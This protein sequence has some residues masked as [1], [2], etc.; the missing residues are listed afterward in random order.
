MLLFYKWQINSV[1]NKKKL[2]FL[3]KLRVRHST[4]WDRCLIDKKKY[5][6]QVINI[7]NKKNSIIFNLISY[8]H[9]FG[10]I[11]SLKKM[12]K[13]ILFFIYAFLLFIFPRKYCNTFCRSGV[14]IQ[15]KSQT[16]FFNNPIDTILSQHNFT[17]FLHLHFY[18]CFSIDIK[19]HT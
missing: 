13:N 1:F 10:N 16:H 11:Y 9:Q 18:L 4:W 12:N 14:T 2:I 8:L 3:P 17:H 6:A 7:Y 19:L 15:N 5:K